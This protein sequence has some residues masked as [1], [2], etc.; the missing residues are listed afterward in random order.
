MNIGELNSIINKAKWQGR[1]EGVI[2]TGFAVAIVCA[3]LLL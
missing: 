2:V 1:C 3:L